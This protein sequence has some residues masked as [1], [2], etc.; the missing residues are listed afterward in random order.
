MAITKE[1]IYDL[2]QVT[3]PH[4]I[5]QVRKRTNVV[6]DGNVIASNVHRYTL[7]PGDS[8]TDEPEEVTSVCNAVWTDAVVTAFQSAT[9][10]SASE[11]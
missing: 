11:E 4:K 1:T 2:V 7:S 6:E 8:L 3:A 9:A 10:A 5:V